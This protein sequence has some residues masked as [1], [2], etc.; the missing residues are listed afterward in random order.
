MNDVKLL[1]RVL[2]GVNILLGLGIVLF[3]FQYL[4]F[5][6]DAK[7]LKDFKQEDDAPAAPQAADR[8]DGALKSLTNP[9]EKRQIDP[10]MTSPTPAILKGRPER[11]GSQQRSGVHQVDG[12]QHGARGLRRRRDPA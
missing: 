11:E 1:N 12:P 10:V 6:P 2:W 5:A 7:Y 8:G 9:V 4:L 3:S